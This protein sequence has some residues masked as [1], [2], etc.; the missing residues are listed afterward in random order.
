MLWTS[1]SKWLYEHLEYDLE[2]DQG[3]I[4][5]NLLP[6]G[7]DIPPDAIL[8]GILI[9]KKYIWRNRCL[10]RGVTLAEWVRELKE[11]EENEAKIATRCNKVPF[12]NLKWGPLSSL[13]GGM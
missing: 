11:V 2:T 10:L 13:M 12:H 8:L 4:L 3:M 6:E 5:M 7:W 9:A 1:I